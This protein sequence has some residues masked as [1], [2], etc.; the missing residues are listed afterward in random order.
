MS[1]LVSFRQ[2]PFVLAM[3]EVFKLNVSHC[4][5]FFARMAGSTNVSVTVTPSGST[6]AGETYSLTC[7][8]A[9]AARNPGGSP[10][11]YVTP[12][13]TFEWLYGPNGNAPLPSGLTQPTTEFNSGTRSYT[14][15]LEFSQLSQSLHT[16]MYTCRLGVGSLVNSNAFAVNGK[17]TSY[18]CSTS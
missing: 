7:S 13:P 14:S 1:I 9:L 16:G 8:A 11:S 18:S 3:I 2:W 15:T 17:C 10:D 6:T 4:T 12:P 5:V